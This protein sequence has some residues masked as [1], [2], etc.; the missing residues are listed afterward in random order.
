MT[1]RAFIT[2]VTMIFYAILV[3]NL[4][5]CQNQEPKTYESASYK[6]FR[7][8]H[9]SYEKYNEFNTQF[10]FQKIEGFEDGA[11]RYYPSSIIKADN[12]YY[13]W[14]SKP[15][16]NSEVVGPIDANDTLRAFH[17]DLCDIWYATST[18]GL[19]W[20]EQGLAVS[21]G[22]AGRYDHRSVFNP[23][24]LFTD[25]KYYL[26]YQ[27]AKS[28]E[29]ARWSKQFRTSGDFTPNVIGMSVG[30]S[31]AGPWK[32][33]DEPILKPGSEES[34]D[35]EVIH[36]PTFFVKGGQFFLYYKS[37]GR[38]PWTPN[39]SPGKF[40]K[41]YADIPLATGVAIA[42]DPKGPYTKSKY[43]PVLMGGH[44]SMV[45]PYRNGVCA[46]LPEGPERNSILFSEDG[47]NFYPKIQGLT[48][49]KGGG[50]YRPGTFTDV[51]TSPGKGITWGISHQLYPNYHFVRFECDL[52]LEKGNRVRKEYK[53]IKEYMNNDSYDYNSK[54]NID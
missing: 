35:A 1:R 51:N 16:F 3:I 18:D 24:I 36:E 22:T 14:Y 8:N 33:L 38:L 54:L 4:T 53:M 39:I 30:N 28:I 25:G 48:I 6:R 32:A 15:Q 44:G 20:E 31:A 49:P 52:S 40:N 9:I 29:N 42:N 19:K 47:I 27:A 46:I 50:A 5:S 23:D 37:H 34:W 2:V 11:E 12:Q 43:N 10:K 7:E 41:D 17:W 26:V 45:W 21:R 13:M